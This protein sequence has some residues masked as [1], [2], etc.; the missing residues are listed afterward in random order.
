MSKVTRIGFSLAVIFSIG[1]GFIGCSGGG[2]GDSSS[3]PVE[4]TQT[5]YLAGS[6]IVAG[7]EIINPFG[8]FK[9]GDNFET[10]VKKTCALDGVQEIRIGG[11]W[12]DRN[13]LCAIKD[14]N[15]Q[16][17]VEFEKSVDKG[18]RVEDMR[19]FDFDN[20]K[21]I[22]STNTYIHAKP[23]I[24]N[25]VSYEMRADLT[26]SGS[27]D[28]IASY[29]GQKNKASVFKT[30]DNETIVIPAF[31]H[32]LSFTPFGDNAKSSFKNIYDVLV[33][34]YS[35]NSNF[36]KKEEY[37]FLK[38]ESDG[39]SIEFSEQDIRY[40]GLE[41]LMSKY[42]ILKEEYLKKM[43]NKKNNTNLSNSL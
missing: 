31:L 21:V 12:L 22:N 25:G 15:Y 7:D 9:W 27:V 3:A 1:L 33:S 38:A 10:V 43:A 5:G 6:G 8:E 40:S 41:H 39:T 23:V 34:K 17:Y 28:K 19:S 35:S 16:K 26:T 13:A 20:N 42:M 29:L 32:D 4:T 30:E 36:V 18:Y 24:I 2:D 37:L 14:F 11:M